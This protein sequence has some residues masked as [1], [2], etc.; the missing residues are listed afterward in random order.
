MLAPDFTV[1]TASLSGAVYLW[2]GGRLDSATG[3]YHF[4]ARDYS[5]T[6]SRWITQD[7]LGLRGGDQ[8]LYRFVG[9]DP[10]VW[11]DPAGTDRYWIGGDDPTDHSRVAVD[12]WK[13][14]DVKYVK[15][16]FVTYELGN[17]GG[18]LGASTSGGGVSILLVGR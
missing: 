13:L 18:W 15:N 5:P 8:N 17:D 1:R 12:K 7:P 14:V 2:Q 11:I 6:L 10:P 16:G 3:L 4:G 9:N